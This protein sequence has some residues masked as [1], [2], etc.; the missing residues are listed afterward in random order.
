MEIEIIRNIYSRLSDDIS[1]DIFEKRL[2]YSISDD[3]RYI[4][5]IIVGLPGGGEKNSKKI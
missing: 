2:L 3:V 4:Q 1:R 5:N